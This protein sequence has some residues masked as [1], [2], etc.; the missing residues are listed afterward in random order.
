M[1]GDA[2]KPGVEMHL[3]GEVDEI[4]QAMEARPLNGLL[5]FPIR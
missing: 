2:L 5:L 1:T 3:M 4:G